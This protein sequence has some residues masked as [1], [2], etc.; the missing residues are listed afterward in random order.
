MTPLMYWQNGLCGIEQLVVNALQASVNANRTRT[1][2]HQ[3]RLHQS[4]KG[5]SL[6]GLD[7]LGR[8]L[9]HDLIV[10]PGRDEKIALAIPISTAPIA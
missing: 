8:V 5:V 10:G 3:Q 2:Q 6:L 7:V 1:E 4:C 9:P